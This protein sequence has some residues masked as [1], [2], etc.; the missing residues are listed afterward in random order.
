ML[1]AAWRDELIQRGCVSFWNERV[2]GIH[3]MREIKFLEFTNRY[4]I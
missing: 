3:S 1:H 4:D 2:R